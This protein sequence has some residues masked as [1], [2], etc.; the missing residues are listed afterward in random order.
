MK[1]T[2]TNHKKE[3]YSNACL[4]GTVLLGCYIS[5]YLLWRIARNR[6][7]HMEIP[8]IHYIFPILVGVLVGSVLVLLTRF[9][10]KKVE[11]WKPGQIVWLE[12]VLYSVW[13]IVCCIWMQAGYYDGRIA[14]YGILGL[15]LGLLMVLTDVT[16]QI[17]GDVFQWLIGASVLFMDI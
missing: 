4:L 3:Q 2:M 5:L 8:V 10:R 17:K 14:D 13:V 1:A 6:V 15:V 7:F 11:A 16:D 12:L 9:V